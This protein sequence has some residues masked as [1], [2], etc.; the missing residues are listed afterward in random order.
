MFLL[1]PRPL[2][3]TPPHSVSNRKMLG[4]SVSHG[5]F[6]IFQYCSGAPA[7]QQ[8]RSVSN[9]SGGGAQIPP[10]RM[11]SGSSQK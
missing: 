4:A 8:I 10:V 6:L 7:M 2:L 5:Y 1:F 3:W 11:A 9:Q